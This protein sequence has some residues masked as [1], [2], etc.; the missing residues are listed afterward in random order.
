VRVWATLKGE[1]EP[2]ELELLLSQARTRNSPLWADDP[3]QQLAY[4]AIKRWSRLYCPDVILGVYSP[5]EFE[6][7]PS[8]KDVNPRP[9]RQTGAQVASRTIEAVAIDQDARDRL[10]ADLDAAADTGT[11]SL[12]Q[13]W[14]ALNKEQRKALA[15]ELNGLKARAAAADKPADA[16]DEYVPE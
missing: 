2:R 1:E 4:L 15:G 6:A 7:A 5:D 10:L 9:A 14:T 13:A 8:I 3:R 12:E 11:E 16:E